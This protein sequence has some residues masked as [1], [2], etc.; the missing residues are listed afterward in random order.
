MHYSE[1]TYLTAVYTTESSAYGFITPT[2]M[3]SRLLA[4]GEP[5]P[6]HI[7]VV[8]ATACTVEFGMGPSGHLISSRQ[9][10]KTSPAALHPHPRYKSS[11]AWETSKC[12]QT[13]LESQTR[14]A[15]EE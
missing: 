4:R 10:A 13:G 8:N 6:T 11:L 9:R 12:Q 1:E 7:Y 14:Q 15:W 2:K 5:T 3:S